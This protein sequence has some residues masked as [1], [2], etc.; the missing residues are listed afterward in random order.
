MYR[1]Y[2]VY[3]LASQA[4]ELFVSVTNDLRRRLAEH[5]GNYD[6]D[7]YFLRHETRRLV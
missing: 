3:I 6:V 7:A 2:F 1:T 4:R 5:G